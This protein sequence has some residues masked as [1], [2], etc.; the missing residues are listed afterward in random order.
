MSPIPS[1]PGRT[2]WFTIKEATMI[3]RALFAVSFAALAF[4]AA[5]ARADLLVYSPGFVYN[6]GLLDL[7]ADFTKQTGVKVMV[8]SVGM[9]TVLQQI[10]TATPAADV[11]VLPMEPFNLM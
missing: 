6:A 10:K 1:S 8:R 9:G 4:F 11:V 7:A 3:N 5:P 2:S